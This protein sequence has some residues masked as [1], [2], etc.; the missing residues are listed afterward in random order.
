MLAKF[1]PPLWVSGPDMHHGT[2]V[3]HVPWCMLGSLTSGFL[4]SRWRGNVTGIPGG[5][6]SHNFTYLVRGPYQSKCPSRSREVSR[7]NIRISKEYSFCRS[8]CEPPVMSPTQPGCPA[9]GRFIPGKPML[10]WQVRSL[11]NTAAITSHSR[12]TWLASPTSSRTSPQV[13][14]TPGNFVFSYRLTIFFMSRRTIQNS[15][16]KNSFCL[17]YNWRLVFVELY[18]CGLMMLHCFTSHVGKPIGVWNRQYDVKL[19]TALPMA[20]NNGP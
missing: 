4:W 17:R 20:L 1:S 9:I 12:H 10:S 8:A 6:A 18:S 15:P 13:I 2:C 19:L 14:D 5:C 7:V 3:T 16:W 11:D